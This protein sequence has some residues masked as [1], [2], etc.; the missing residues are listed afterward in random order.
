MKIVRGALQQV[1]GKRIPFQS[2]DLTLFAAVQERARQCGGSLA[3]H[4]SSGPVQEKI[5]APLA[6][7]A[8]Q[9]FGWGYDKGFS[10]P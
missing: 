2:R 1:L 9:V 5:R 8:A 6:L 7:G 3:L 4:G 10:L